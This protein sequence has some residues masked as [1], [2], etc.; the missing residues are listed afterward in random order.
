MDIVTIEAARKCTGERLSIKR[1]GKEVARA[2]LY[3]LGN[4]LH[5]EPFG[6]MEDVYVD[7]S[8]RGKSIGSFLIVKVI[9]RARALGCYKLIATSRHVRHK[10]HELYLKLG[11]VNYGVEFRMDL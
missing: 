10:V 8:L 4:D 9:E 2:F 11:F 6:L 5:Q 7:V 1:G 3:I